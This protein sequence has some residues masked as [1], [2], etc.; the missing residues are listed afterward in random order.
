[1]RILIG[2]RLH[3]VLLVVLGLAACAPCA[4]A[5]VPAPVTKADPVRVNG[6]GKMP[7]GTLTTEVTYSDTAATA[8]ASTGDTIGLAPGYSFRLRTCV[9]YHLSGSAP[10]STCAERGVDTPTETRTVLTHAPP[11][12]LSGQPRP[13]TQPWGYFTAYSEVLH[14]D[15]GAWPLSAH[16]WPD[17]G[18]QGAG[19]PVAAQGQTDGA[20]PPN[21][22]VALDGAYAGAVNT[23]EPDSICTATPTV[24]D[25]SPLP[26]GVSSTHAAFSGAPAYYEVGL[27]TGAYAGQA[28][29]GVMLVIHGGGW[30]KTGVGAVQS[31]RPDADRW[32]A[33]GWETVNLTYGAC[34]Q[35]L[36]DALWF[37]DRARA[38]FGAGAKVCALGTSAGAHLALLIGAYRPDLYCAVSQAG[39]TDLRT[40]QTQ[41]AYDRASG[42]HTQTLGGRWVHNLAAAAFGEENLGDYSPVALASGTLKRTRVLQALPADDPVIPHQQATDLATAMRAADLTAYVDDLQMAVGRIP[43]GHGGV[44]PAVLD[45]FHAREARL[46]APITVPTVPLRRR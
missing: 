34:A 39:P 12:T 45:D 30:V 24:S 3:A 44:A 29:R 5:N 18:L 11:V 35:T 33:R 28:P 15:A 43:F 2:H 10:V 8:T 1:V 32:R 20:L 17:S 27:P 6:L 41:V 21:G 31:M 16:S 25:G 22:A 4:A 38:W 19:I 40:I 46:V 7:N 36:P 37:Y 42:L 14:Q 13:T 9:A 26:A 23:G